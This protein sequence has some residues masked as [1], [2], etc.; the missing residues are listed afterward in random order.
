M[1]CLFCIVNPQAKRIRQ[2][3]VADVSF[4]N[5]KKKVVTELSFSDE[6][7]KSCKSQNLM[8]INKFM[9]YGFLVAFAHFL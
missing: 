6:N 2:N 5:N 8:P 7:K 1:C 4:N 3:M 9:P